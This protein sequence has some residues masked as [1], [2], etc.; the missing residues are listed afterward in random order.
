[1][2][3]PAFLSTSTKD[4]LS[5]LDL[6]LLYNTHATLLLFAGVSIASI[7]RRLGHASMTTMQ[8]TYLHSI[9]ELENK[10]IPSSCGHFLH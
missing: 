3:F 6:F 9:Q 7:A 10:D 5:L 8:K 2:G 4:T 1:M